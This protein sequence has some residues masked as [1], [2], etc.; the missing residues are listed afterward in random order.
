M[1]QETNLN[2]SP[3]FD[4]FNP[5]KEYYKVLFKPGY[6]VQARELNNLQSILQNQIENF[7]EYFF[8]EGAKVIPGNTTYIKNYDCVELENLYI[9]VP[10]NQ[11]TEQLVGAK[12]TGRDSGVQG[13]VRQVVDSNLS[14]RGSTILY[15]SY[16][17]TGND[18]AVEKFF[19]GELLVC[20]TT[21]TSSNSII[22][23][24]EPFA[25]TVATNAVSVGSAYAISNGVY[26]AKGTFLLVNDETIILDQFSD[27]PN[28]RIGL[29]ITEELV[30]S[31]V[32]PTLNDNSRGYTNYSAPGADRLKMTC[33]LHKKDLDDF[34]DNDFVEL[35]TVQNGVL[36]TLRSN[37]E[38]TEFQNLLAKRT[39]AE[40]GDY[41]AKPFD[42]TLR[43]SLNNFEDNKGIFNI[44]QLT[45]GG[46]TPSPD[47]ALYKISP[48]RAFVKGY[49]IESETTLYLDCPKPRTFE[50]VESQAI[51]FNTGPSLYLNRVYGVP[52]V[53]FGNTYIVSL[54]DQRIGESDSDA[55]GREIG[56]ARVYDFKL[57]SGSYDA[58]NANVNEWG[59]SLFDIQTTSD[60][61]LNEV[62]SLPVPTFVEGKRSGATA[63]LKD[64]VSAGKTLTVY[65]ISGDFSQAEPFI[66]NGIPNNR[67][68]VAITNH[69]ISDVKSI[70]GE[71]G[72]KTFNADVIQT[73]G[74]NIGVATMTAANAGVATV[75]AI[76][77]AFPTAAKVGDIVRYTNSTSSSPDQAFASVVSVGQ[78]DIT[79]T[80]VTTV[81]GVCDGALPTQPISISN[82]SIRTT[83]LERSYDNSLYT[84]LPKENIESVSLDDAQIAIRKEYTVNIAANRMSN[85]I[86][87]GANSF[88]E[89]FTPERYL[90]I[91]SDGTT[92]V[93]TSDK[94]KFTNGFQNLD[95]ENLGSDD[96]GAT[97]ITTVKKTVVTSKEK[98][99]NR[100]NAVVIDKSTNDSSG[101][102]T[103]TLNDGLLTGN[104]PYGTR[105]QDKLISLNVPDVIEIHAVYESLNFNDPSAPTCVLRNITGPTATTRDIIPGEKIFGADS[106]ALAIVP[107]I[108]SDSVI[109]FIPKNDYNFTEGEQ[110][111]FAESN[112]TATINLINSQ[113][114]N[115]TDNYVFS[116]GQKESFYDFGAIR[117]I[118]RAVPASKKLKVYFTSAYYKVSD[119]GDVTIAN[120][121]AGFD[122]TNE[123]KSINGIRNTDM[124]D[125]RPRVAEFTPDEDVRSPFEFLGRQ[126]NAAGQS[127]G[128]I[129][130]SDETIVA[131]FNFYLGRIDRVFL[132]KDGSF[133][134]KYGTPAEEPENPIS[135]DNAIEISRINLP[136]YLYRVEDASVKF[137]DYKR[138]QMKDIKNL[139][140]RIR[141]LEYYTSLSMLEVNTA[142]LFLPD[143][144]GLNRFK[145]GFFVDNFTTLLTQEDG[146]PLK[147]SIDIRNKELRAQHFT[148][149]VDLIPG[150]VEGVAADL[151]LQFLQP[152]G[153]GIRQSNG[154]V[155]LDYTEE[156]WFEQ[157]FGTRDESVT[158]Y[159]LAF[160]T[161]VMELTP[162]SDTWVDQVR[163]DALVTDIEGDYTATLAIASREQNVDPQTGM[164]PI[165]WNS[166][167]DNW[168]GSTFNDFTNRRTVF[169]A[170]GRRRT[171]TTFEDTFRTTTDTGIST[172][173]GTRTVITEQFDRQSLGD[174]VINR[175]LISF[176]RSRNIQFVSKKS[177]PNTQLYPFFDGVDVSAFCVPKLLEV[178]MLAG[179]FQVGE[180]VIG[181]VG[182]V[183]LLPIER[184][185]DPTIT[186]RVAQSDH[187][188]G[189]FNAPTKLYPIN[190]YDGK[191][192]QSAYSSSSTILNVD[193]FSLS[194]QPQGEFSGWVRR[195]M[196][197]FGQKSGAVA[198]VSDVRLISDISATVI[199]S[200]FIPNPTAANAPQFETGESVF[201]LINTPTN[202]INNAV[203]VSDATFTSSGT[204]ETVQENILSIRNARTEI[205]EEQEERA[206]T[207]EGT[208][209]IN[210]TIVNQNS[211]VVNPPRRDPLA[212]SFLVQEPEGIFITKCDIF[213][214][215]KDK[216]NIPLIFQIRTMDNGVPTE[217]VLPLSEVIV[218]PDDIILSNDG[219]IPTSIELQ[220]P[221]YLEG[222]IEYAIVMLSDS[223]EYRV[224]ISRVGEEDL[225][226]QTF[227]SNQPTLGSLFKSQNGATWDPSQWED[228]KFTLYRA[229]FVGEGNLVMYNPELAIGNGQIPLL[230]PDS[231]NTVSRTVKLG[232]D[233]SLFDPAVQ[234]GNVITQVGTQASGI[235]NGN[236]GIATGELNIVN[237]GVGYTPTSGSTTYDNVPLFNISSDG[238]SATADITIEDGVAIAATIRNAGLGYSTGDV[239]GIDITGSSP[240][241]V[242][243]GAQF[244]ITG[245]GSTNQIILTNVQGDFVVSAGFANTVQYIQ[246]GI[247]SDLNGVTAQVQVTDVNE[248]NDGLHF[249]VDHRNHGMYFN[250]NLVQ[251]YDIA[252]DCIPTRTSVE[253]STREPVEILIDN[254]NYDVIENFGTFENINV[255]ATNPGY[256][257]IGKE[258][259]EYTSV[260]SDR[261]QGITRGIDTSS[262][263]VHPA[264]SKITKYELSGVSLR[265]L[266]KIHN[267]EDVDV[268]IEEPITFDKYTIKV[269]MS[270][271]GVDRTQEQLTDLPNLTFNETKSAG[272]SI[273]RATQNIPY[274]LITPMVQN[275]T[276]P[277]TS[278]NGQIRTIT[279]QGLNGDEIAWRDNGFEPVSLNETNYLKSSR[280]MASQVNADDKLS[281]LPGN[282][283]FTMNINLTTDDSTLSPL[284]DLRR[285][286]T[287]L[288]SNRVN[289]PI[290][291]YANDPRVNSMTD[292][293][294][295]FV[296]ITKEFALENPATSLKVLLN[297]NVTAYADVRCF[298]A[299]NDSANFD[300]IFVPFPGY[301][302][303]DNRGRIIDFANNDGKPDSFVP[304]S[305]KL[306]FK[307]DD[308]DFTEYSFT[309]NGLPTFRSYRL[310]IVMTST[311]QA[312]VPRIRDLR[313]IAL[314]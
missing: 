194:N 141:S 178:F 290:T 209:R 103:D 130:A 314:A 28:Y 59:I 164:S 281:L 96:I 225:V 92:E 5:S 282:K 35:G 203:T 254:T 94:M 260:L 43:E 100:T 248:V 257:L 215:K 181:R 276:V 233:Q 231:I 80:G 57:E 232:L 121:Y 71:V 274:E 143:D 27:T 299:T 192:M 126:F 163:V 86:G 219:S 291:D 179:T 76:N 206:I 75:S 150:P 36:R 177:K 31:D 11:Y 253:I 243:T 211:W 175:S 272:G 114:A 90:L 15:I 265:R 24:G 65:Q 222:G 305:K 119:D 295:A 216:N 1:P 302:N 169:T 110:V 201:R 204:L 238:E 135:V 8:K 236:A 196:R 252:P 93:L 199:G 107:E 307:T 78:S 230:E 70:Y 109:T 142:N 292:D 69:T 23:P 58:N 116:T 293:P 20:D 18:N 244:S 26:F 190:P 154:V 262:K 226:T 87:A 255:S 277:G 29:L 99:K 160:W 306:L 55:S 7:G 309:M 286:N 49:D 235:Y 259:I 118:D 197:L 213:F 229:D 180:T 220:A 60:I 22:A 84:P 66:F 171:L 285:V 269:D 37:P 210:T 247:K 227:V 263:F 239:L 271:N 261:L 10:I 312:Y 14:E 73:I 63:F 19:D 147:N 45:Y 51:E 270:S 256:V 284:I 33:A 193:T 301:D 105:V 123:I 268:D 303:L 297:A 184:S 140:D 9:G 217:K 133:I 311:N 162:E 267:L 202:D 48:G 145:S 137:L 4:D 77:P 300:P 104:Y 224:Y 89:P 21:L 187:K 296:Y 40:S 85:R 132:S 41:Y 2:A 174:R 245:I 136:P 46:S 113:S 153:N 214:S 218:D 212:Q 208:Q 188:E 205:V 173:N 34:D 207:R 288:T 251:L 115:V 155:S 88:F 106:N 172:R 50:T 122:Y 44:D 189:P 47:L 313:T 82:F 279:A 275:I 13:V 62:I 310:K 191:V 249:S 129:I 54:M 273:T 102:G 308:L 138:Y 108:L 131:D 228:L 223:A 161:G 200:F 128:N 283:S 264:G 166:W 134:V 95:I 298:Y 52:E 61:E 97:L 120:S 266:N 237:A 91:R 74:A 159:I 152:E 278:I 139:E 56:Y 117:R 111:T 81:P 158:P 39:Y 168:T 241:E 32:D 234:L 165:L 246:A 240:I 79:I 185:L 42:T 242:G 17:A 64:A 6:P 30:N 68:A 38:N 72:I 151:D 195:G 149:S 124:L 287:I 183:G 146:I 186:F 176:M 258:V 289:Q 156:V 101:I 125:V 250:E 25:S 12:V 167:Q 221:V 170:S 294:N 53:G 67:V 83:N 16:I 157:V 198:Q 280:L 3:Y 304:K 144:V 127:A 148:T 182:D 112:I 98:F